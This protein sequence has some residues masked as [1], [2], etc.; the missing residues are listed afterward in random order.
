MY[1]RAH[2]SGYLQLIAEPLTPFPGSFPHQTQSLRWPLLT[3]TMIA[4]Q[5]NMKRAG[6]TQDKRIPFSPSFK[7][8]L[9]RESG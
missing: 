2:D 7:P 5:N 1:S 9:A 3:T 8:W 6:H 4:R